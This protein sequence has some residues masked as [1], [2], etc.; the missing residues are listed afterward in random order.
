MSIGVY[1]W[2]Y[3]IMHNER[4]K[5]LLK[6]DEKEKQYLIEADKAFRDGYYGYMLIRIYAAIINQLYERL[7]KNFAIGERRLSPYETINASLN[8]GIITVGEGEFLNRIRHLR[9]LAAHDR[10]ADMKKGEAKEIFE[11]SMLLVKKLE[12]IPKA[13]PK[14]RADP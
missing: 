11:K 4:E 10:T 8:A 14:R 6:L 12:K 3:R 13:N 7:V 5:L 1:Y 2:T 9:N